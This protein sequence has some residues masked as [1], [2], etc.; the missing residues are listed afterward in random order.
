MIIQVLKNITNILELTVEVGKRNC[1]RLH[2][3]ISNGKMDYIGDVDFK[4]IHSTEMEGIQC[5]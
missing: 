5:H 2:N 4:D 1:K 3:F